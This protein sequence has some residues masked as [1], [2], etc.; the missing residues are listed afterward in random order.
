MKRV[1]AVFMSE[2]LHEK[3]RLE[4]SELFLI[5]AKNIGLRKIFLN[6]SLHE[7]LVGYSLAFLKWDSGSRVNQQVLE[8]H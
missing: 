3:F 2:E 7:A 5:I 4:I 6:K 1:I 8:V